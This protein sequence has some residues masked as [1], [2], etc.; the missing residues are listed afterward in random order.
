MYVS[1]NFLMKFKS[2]RNYHPVLNFL[3][4]EEPDATKKIVGEFS[5]S[6]PYDDLMV[7]MCL[8]LLKVKS[9]Q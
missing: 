1:Y 9:S 6:L 2:L 3:F 4:P 5:R 7:T 8:L